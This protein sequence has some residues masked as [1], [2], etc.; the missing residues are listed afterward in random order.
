MARRQA[1]TREESSGRLRGWLVAVGKGAIGA[2]LLI[3]AVAGGR[4]LGEPSTLPVETV[5]VRGDLA[6]LDRD[7]LKRVVIPFAQS[8]FLRLDMAGLRTA[9]EELSWVYRATVRRTWPATLVIAVEEQRPVA[10]WEEGG[11]VN[12]HGELFRSDGHG[13]LH[14]L[15]VLNGPPGSSRELAQ[16]YREVQG[17]LAALGVRPARLR[18]TPRRAWTVTLDNGLELNLGRRN[19]ERRLLRFVRTY[20]KAIA[21]RLADIEAVDLRYTNGFAVRWKPGTAPTA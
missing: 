19:M 21:P 18:V 1:A 15:P 14:G 4:W 9:V 12:Q 11:F 5:R 8:G 16:H 13:P 20:G 10:I 2:V 6:H 7:E 17:M 3:G